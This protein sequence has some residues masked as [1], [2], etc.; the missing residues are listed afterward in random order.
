[1]R[2]LPIV[3]G[4][5]TEAHHRLIHE[6]LLKIREFLNEPSPSRRAGCHQT[7]PEVEDRGL[8]QMASFL[9]LRGEGSYSDTICSHS[10]NVKVKLPLKGI[11][12][13]TYRS[14]DPVLTSQ[15]PFKG[16]EARSLFVY[17]SA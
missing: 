16:I 15:L 3:L 1:M 5:K 12:L 2:V 4:K 11:F 17:K 8:G 10:F 9:T 7:K 14:Y 6:S 13:P